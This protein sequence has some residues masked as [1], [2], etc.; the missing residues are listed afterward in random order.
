MSN[1]ATLEAQTQD[2]KARLAQLKSVRR[3]Q[4]PSDE[5]SNDSSQ[6]PL[7][8]RKTPTPSSPSDDTTSA[9]LSGRNYDPATRGPK[10]GFETQPQLTQPTVE[11]QA[12]E[13]AEAAKK[14]S[15]EEEKANKPLDMFKLQ[16]RKANWDLKR[17]LDKRMEVLNVRTENAM[18]RIVRERIQ[19][20]Q[21]EAKERAAL[22]NDHKDQVNGNGDAEGDGEAIGM[23]GNTLVEATREMEREAAVERK[24]SDEEPETA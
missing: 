21:K 11:S 18:A 1:Y 6:P 13:L 22:N 4:A 7:A 17:E 14:Q 3:K 23:E 19:M 12:K 9:F 10:L 2:R 8:K 24:H 15:E 5:A 16:P 20:A